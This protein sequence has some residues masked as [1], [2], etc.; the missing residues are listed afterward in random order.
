M[1]PIIPMT[2]S[3]LPMDSE[4]LKAKLLRQPAIFACQFS[5][6]L[7]LQTIRGLL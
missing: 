2:S 5:I 3:K 6:D 4:H 1:N 7:V